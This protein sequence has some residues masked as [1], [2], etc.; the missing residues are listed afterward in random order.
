[1]VLVNKSSELNLKVFHLVKS[2]I[3]VFWIIINNKKL[4]NK[5]K[6]ADKDKTMTNR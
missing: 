4:A 5:T 1:M 6:L 2:V 3:I